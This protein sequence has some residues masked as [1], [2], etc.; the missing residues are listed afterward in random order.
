MTGIQIC[1][2]AIAGVTAISVVKKWNADF[3]PLLRIALTVLLIG[4][5]LAWISPLLTYLKQLTDGT[6]VS[7]SAQLL[8]KALGIAYLTQICANVCRESGENGAAECVELA[9][10]LEILLLALPLLNQ[11]LE[12]VERLLSLQV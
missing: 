8:F 7:Q 6:G 12:T 3:L 10:K 2:L 5:A 1:M 4:G 9:G 11:I